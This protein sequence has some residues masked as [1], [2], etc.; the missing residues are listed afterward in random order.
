MD[1]IE[2][3]GLDYRTITK[4]EQKIADYLL[5]DTD[6]FIYMTL[7]ELSISIG[8]GEA[9]IVRFCKKMGYDGF[10]SFKFEIS[11]SR[12]GED[13]EK[14]TSLINKIKDNINSVVENTANSLDIDSINQAVKMMI[15]AQRLTF[16][17]VGSSGL[18]AL[19]A[20]N[21]FLRLGV[22]VNAITDSHFQLMMASTANKD[23]VLVAISLSG[24][25]DDILATVRLAKEN[26]CKIISL[27]NSQLSSLAKESDCLIQTAV[28]ENILAGGSLLAKI[29]QLYAMDCLITSYGIEKKEESNL[30]REKT[31]RSIISKSI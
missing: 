13:D 25:T 15:K 5:S 21:R 2:K 29:S 1:Y 8:V 22:Y 26:G 9:S 11:K 3:F 31:A 16:V 4:T 28:R 7:H 20:Q 24:S 27:T 6:D 23:D 10:Q 19:E 12:V 17:G 18:V 30:N 14:E